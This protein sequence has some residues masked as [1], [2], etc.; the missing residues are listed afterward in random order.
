MDSIQSLHYCLST[1]LIILT[2]EQLF[3][4]GFIENS[5]LLT[6]SF[7]QCFNLMQLAFIHC[8][9]DLRIRHNKQPACRTDK[10]RIQLINIWLLSKHI[11]PHIK[12]GFD[13]YGF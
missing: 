10:E 6:C 9:N 4:R 7:K 12:P 8:Q 3:F 2:G 11:K 1:F 13:H 5:I